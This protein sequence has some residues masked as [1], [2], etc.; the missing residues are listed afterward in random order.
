MSLGKYDSHCMPT[1]ASFLSMDFIF[2]QFEE[3]LQWYVMR[4][5]LIMHGNKGGCIYGRVKGNMIFWL[6][7]YGGNLS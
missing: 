3:K 5:K 2:V 7:R 4:C 1:V 6:V